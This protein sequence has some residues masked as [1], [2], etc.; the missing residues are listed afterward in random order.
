LVLLLL[1]TERVALAGHPKRRPSAIALEATQP[2]RRER[3]EKTG[4]RRWLGLRWNDRVRSLVQLERTVGM[5]LLGRPPRRPS[6][7]R[8]AGLE[9]LHEWWL[10]TICRRV[11][12][13]SHWID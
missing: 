5:A 7:M 8:L 10:A 1:R 9:L 12:L 4:H 6:A 11:W 13:E 3:L 2:L